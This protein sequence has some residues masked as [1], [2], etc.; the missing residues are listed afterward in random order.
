MTR[1]FRDW[2]SLCGAAL[3]A[4]SAFL[5]APVDAATPQRCAVASQTRAIDFDLPAAHAAIRDGKKLT[6]VAIGSSS[7]AGSGASDDTKSYPAVLQS[8]L[9]R[10][11]PG[12]EITVINRGVGGESVMQMYHRLEGDVIDEEPALVIWQTGVND[13]ITD[14]GLD[15]F[16]R[17]LRKGIAKLRESGA[18]VV[19]MDQ[20]PL[21]RMER[22]PLY[23][24]YVAALREVAAET[25][26]A[27]YRRYDVLSALLKEGRLAENE[28]FAADALH[29]V[30]ASYFC[31]AS[32]LA[33]SIAEK[34][35]P[36]AAGVRP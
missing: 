23:A 29:Q 18:D 26:T 9:S 33:Q 11:L 16:K 30:D 25:Q 24:D 12:H 20:Q 14:R 6:I 19:L 7:T 13:A 34:L 8:E 1:A 10:L 21:P 22:Y 4:I 31:I 28:I 2:I 17:L 27:V 32:T 3:V 36:R 15:R 35:S 5:A